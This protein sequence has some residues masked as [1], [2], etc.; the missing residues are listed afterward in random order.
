MGDLPIAGN[1][2]IC[3]KGVRWDMYDD[4]EER[5]L[6]LDGGAFVKIHAGYGSRLD[7]MEFKTVVCD[8]CLKD[9]MHS[10]RIIGIRDYM[11]DPGKTEKDQVFYT[12]EDH[13]MRLKVAWKH[14]EQTEKGREQNRRILED[15]GGRKP[16]ERKK[17]SRP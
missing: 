9:C 1:C 3:S 15:T 12:V 2:M 8:E 11:S 16:W 14:R 10:D 13:F 7:T 4:Q 5:Y 17:T 6:N